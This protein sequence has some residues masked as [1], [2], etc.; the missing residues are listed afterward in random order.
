MLLGQAFQ[1]WG[2]TGCFCF[3]LLGLLKVN[4]P[5]TFSAFFTASRTPSLS[6]PPD[7]PTSS[8][9][10]GALPEE[11]SDE[12]SSLLSPSSLSP[13]SDEIASGSIAES[14]TASFSRSS[15]SGM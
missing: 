14:S 12:S 8:E 6:L 15:S 11:P 7:T 2:A 4:A 3:R 10:R 1:S 9:T 5:V 13:S